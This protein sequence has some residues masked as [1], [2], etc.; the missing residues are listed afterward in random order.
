MITDGRQ[1]T[2]FEFQNGDNVRCGPVKGML[3]LCAIK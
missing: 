1:A 3:T 2:Q